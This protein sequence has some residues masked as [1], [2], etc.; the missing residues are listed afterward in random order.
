MLHESVSVQTQ[1]LLFFVL[2]FLIEPPEISTSIRISPSAALL[3]NNPSR[4]PNFSI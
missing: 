3:E 4:L 2:S 1:K